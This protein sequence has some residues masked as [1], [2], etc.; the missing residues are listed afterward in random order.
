MIDFNVTPKNLLLGVLQ[1]SENRAIPISVLTQLGELFGFSSNVMRVNVTRMLS[2]NT[3]EKDE[4]GY[5]RLLKQENLVSQ[6]VDAW[7][8]GEERRTPW[9]NSWFMCLLPDKRKIT[10]GKAA[11]RAFSYMGFQRSSETLW[12]R[13]NNLHINKNQCI[14]NLRQLGVD[15][16]SQLFIVTD[17]EPN[18]IDQWRHELWPT[19]TLQTNYKQLLRTLQQSQQ[20]LKKMSLDKA[21]AESFLTGSKVVNTLAID[22]LLPEEMMEPTHREQ[23]TQAMVEYDVIGKKIWWDKFLELEFVEPLTPSHLNFLD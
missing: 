15:Q 10:E 6:I 21:V 13:P 14:N 18:V 2:S 12:V 23:L 9:D 8:L 19:K 4:R 22:P 7:H 3:L 5:Y 11:H 1:A 20:K 16:A 17:A